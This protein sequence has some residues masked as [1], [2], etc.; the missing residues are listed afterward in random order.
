MISDVN[1][2]SSCSVGEE[3]YEIRFM[4]GKKRIQYDYRTVG[5]E[6]FSCVGK[7]LE[8]CRNKRDKFL[9]S[10]SSVIDVSKD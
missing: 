7:T 2:C 10:L 5:G 8:D 1:G 4:W 3:K 9:D 6:L